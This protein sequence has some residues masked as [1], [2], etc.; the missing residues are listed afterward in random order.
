MSLSF[1][2]IEIPDDLKGFDISH[3]IYREYL[4]PGRSESYVI[5]Y[6]LAL[7]IRPGG[8]SHRVIDKDGLAHCI[9]MAGTIV[10]WFNGEG[11]PPCTF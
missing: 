10:R 2:D 1:D 3:E 6:P 4:V 9:P 7:M 5:D 8:A 11:E